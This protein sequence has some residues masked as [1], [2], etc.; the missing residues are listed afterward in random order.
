MKM[1]EK[2]SPSFCLQVYFRDIVRAGF[3]ARLYQHRSLYNHRDCLLL[4]VYRCRSSLLLRYIW[5]CGRSWLTLDYRTLRHIK[6]VV[7]NL[8]FTCSGQDYVIFLV[9]LVAVEEWHSSARRQSAEWNLA[10]SGAGGFL[11]ELFSFEA[12]QRADGCV[13]EF[14]A[15]IESLDFASYFLVWN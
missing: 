4:P 10:W 11:N 15:G 2:L 9:S 7:V 13:G 3:Y 14:I 1:A 6:D 8:K 5:D 12:T